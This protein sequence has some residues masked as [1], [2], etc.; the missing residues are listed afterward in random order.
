MSEE[1]ENMN[2]DSII[3][4]A[5][6]KKEENESEEPKV[7]EENKATVGDIVS[8]LKDGKEVDGIVTSAKLEN[9]VVVDMT[10]MENFKD[11]GIEHE[12][13]VVGHGNYTLKER[14]NQ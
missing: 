13:T 3:D 1:N 10:I 14:G 12:K 9:S 7:S 6:V 8:F 4:A 2:K 5:F 11:L